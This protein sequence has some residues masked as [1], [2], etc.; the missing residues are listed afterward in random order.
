MHRDIKPENILMS[1]KDGQAKLADLGVSCQLEE[2]MKLTSTQGTPQFMAPEIHNSSFD[3]F[4]AK[5]TDIWSLGITLYAFIS[6]KTPF[7]SENEFE[8]A[9]KT[10]NEVAPKI[11]N[12]SDLLNDLMQKMISKNVDERPTATE[13]LEHEWFKS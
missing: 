11:E 12:A 7:W 10:Q 2:D 4:L 3:G 5:P 8:I 1:S 13:V 9:N 6:S